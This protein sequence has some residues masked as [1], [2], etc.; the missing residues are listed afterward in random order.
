M[1]F[2]T[3]E[4]WYRFQVCH[5]GWS[6]P[7]SFV[8]KVGVESRRP[9]R[10]RTVKVLAS[11]W[12]SQAA[13]AWRISVPDP[14]SMAHGKPAVSAGTRRGCDEVGVQVAAQGGPQDVLGVIDSELVIDPEARVPRGR[15]NISLKVAAHRL[16][17]ILGE[18]QLQNQVLIGRQ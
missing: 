11:H 10:R 3:K 9:F 4:A 16:V 12:A 18:A 15:V 6:M 8:K 17:E 5:I 14:E 1:R 7:S 13:P 2:S